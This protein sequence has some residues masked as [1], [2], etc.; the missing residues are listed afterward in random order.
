MEFIKKSTRKSRYRILLFAG[1]SGSQI[2]LNI[3]MVLLTLSILIMG[4]NIRKIE[5]FEK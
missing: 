3:I 1:L 2:V 5:K 4:L